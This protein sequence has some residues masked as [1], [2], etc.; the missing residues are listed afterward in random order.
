MTTFNMRAKPDHHS[1]GAGVSINGAMAHG[2]VTVQLDGDDGDV[3]EFVAQFK[4]NLSIEE[5]LNAITGVKF[6]DLTESNATLTKKD[7][8]VVLVRYTLSKKERRQLES[9]LTDEVISAA[10]KVGVRSLIGGGRTAIRKS[11][12]LSLIT[13]DGRISLSFG[14]DTDYI[15]YDGQHVIT[16]VLTAIIDGEVGLNV[17]FTSLVVEHTTPSEYTDGKL[18]EPSKVF[19]LGFSYKDFELINYSKLRAGLSVLGYQVSDEDKNTLKVM[20]KMLV[21]DYVFDKK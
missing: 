11:G 17:T 14:A 18:V 3:F 13:G 10:A 7:S 4:A 19:S 8:T 16:G 15:E 12:S 21:D 9:L 2:A 20:V 5:S 1:L 6:I